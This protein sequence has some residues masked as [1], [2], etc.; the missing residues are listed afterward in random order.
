[1]NRRWD[2]EKA[3]SLFISRGCILLETDYINSHIKMK[4]LATCGHEHQISLD[5]FRAGKGNLCYVCRIKDVAE[6][7]RYTYAEVRTIFV[8]NGCTLLS[9][10]YVSASSEKLAYIAQCG[11][12]N[13]IT[14]TKFLSGS[15]RIC[16]KCSKSIRY[17]QDY[18][19]EYFASKDCILLSKYRNCKTPLK[20]IAACGH[21]HVMTFDSFQAPNTTN[22]CPLCSNAKRRSISDIEKVFAANGCTL[23]SNEYIPKRKLKYIAQCGHECEIT[24][25][26]FLDGQGR[27]CSKCAKPRGANHHAY[28]PNLTDEDR[29]YRRDLYDVIIWR[30]AIYAKDNYICVKCKH[31]KGGDL[32]AHHLDGYNW[33]KEKRFDVTNG[34]TLCE[35]CHKE[36]HSLY[37]FGNNT[38]EQYFEWINAKAD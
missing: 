34:I 24:L 4:Y 6:R 11:H 3:R 1:M 16:N 20:Y 35:R 8:E 26:K 2:L 29:I 28:N 31:G 7:Q 27:L 36:F 5:N 38:K 10:C 37:G 15:G 23:K 33:C 21:E 22:V 13:K 14:F 32:I 30:N 19:E 12:E 9:D 18:V 25:H 17:E